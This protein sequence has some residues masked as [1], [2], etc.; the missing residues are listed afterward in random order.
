[1]KQINYFLIISFL[2]FII[3]C[4]SPIMINPYQNNEDNSR[5]N[6]DDRIF[7]SDISN[8][9]PEG[10]LSW[11]DIENGYKGFFRVPSGSEGVK[12]QNFNY[13]FGA[14]CIFDDTHILLEGHDYSKEARKLELPTALD[15]SFAIV[16]GNWYDP[17]GGLL[18]TGMTN[19]GGY[20]LGD[21][22]KIED[23]IYFSKHAWYNCGTDYDSFGYRQKNTSFEDGN[24]FGMWNA[25]HILA[26]NMRIGGYMCNSPDYLKAEGVT[27][28]AGQEGLSGSAMGRWGPNLFAVKFDDTIPVGAN[29]NVFPLVAHDFNK[30]APCWWIA[31]RVYSVAWIETPVK[32]GV[33]MLFTR[34]YGDTW[35][36]EANANNHSDP[37][38][39]GKG[40]HSTGKQLVAWVY[41]PVDLMKVYNQ[42]V[43][44][45]NIKPVYEKVLIDLKPGQ[46]KGAEKFFSFFKFM[47]CGVRMDMKDNRLIFI[48]RSSGD[49]P[50]GFVVDL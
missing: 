46:S 21:L 24:S 42:E 37:Y 31:N 10:I 16:Q 23:R 6:E 12:D 29:I 28:L 13:S 40:Y 3:A 49:K 44:P 17:T 14:F 25:D 26:N 34:G 39:G 27:F 20:R 33:L 15:G 8:I 19:P 18:S 9:A 35:Y 1:M 50:M 48:K 38:G 45:Y 2:F 5:P 32:R 30:E 43:E 36:G 47:V 11:D 7:V 4:N 22:L 41:D